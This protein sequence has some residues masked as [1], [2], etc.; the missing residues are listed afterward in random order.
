MKENQLRKQKSL[1]TLNPSAWAQCRLRETSLCHSWDQ[2]RRFFAALR[3]TYFGQLFSSAYINLWAEGLDPMF[4]ED[5][6]R[7][8]HVIDLHDQ[9]R[10]IAIETDKR[11]ESFDINITLL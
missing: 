5:G 10:L 7:L 4:L 11:V 3:K 6:F 8:Q 2:S 9:D 1:V